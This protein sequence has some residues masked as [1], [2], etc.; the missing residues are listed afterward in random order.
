MF[1]NIES[2]ITYDKLLYQN[3]I[4]PL[5]TE[6]ALIFCGHG[7]RDALLVPSA[8]GDASDGPRA[9]TVFFDQS[10]IA[11]GP[12]F[13]LAFCSRAAAEL[14]KSYEEVTT[15]R[16]FIGF[17]HK[18]GLLLAEGIYAQWWTRIIHGMVLAMLTEEDSDKLAKSIF[19]LYRDALKFFSSGEGHRHK[20]SL[21]MRAYL[22]SQMEALRII[23]T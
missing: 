5:D 19:D 11:L 23:R 12:E 4:D 15:N 7:E 3:S 14:G 8:N 18:I 17:E 2:S 13:L 20:W 6:I 21:M 10:H 16:T 22:R 9:A 1:C